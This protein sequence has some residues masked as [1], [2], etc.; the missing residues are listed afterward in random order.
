M[1]LVLWRH[2]EAEEGSDDAARALT[3]KGEKQAARMAAW[4]EAHLPKGALMIVSP[5]VRAQQTARSLKREAKT[6]KQV[7]TG[8]EPGSILEAAGWPNGAGTVVVVGHQPTLGAAA[9]LALTGQAAGWGLK[10]GAVWWIAS[11]EGEAAPR[12]VAVIS[13]DLLP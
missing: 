8:A 5:A 9:A 3:L 11:R 2:A 1:D 13:P 7:A 4:L 6:S 12:V 10:Q